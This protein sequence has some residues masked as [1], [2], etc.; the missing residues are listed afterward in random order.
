LRE[1][2][3]LRLLLE[4]LEWLKMEGL[5][6]GTVATSFSRRLLQPTQDHVHT[7]YE[8]WGAI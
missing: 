6:C 5:T 8:Y 1:T 4:D 3:E 2:D 7:A